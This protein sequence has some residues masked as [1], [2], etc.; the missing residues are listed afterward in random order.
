[1]AHQYKTWRE[2]FN[3][4]VSNLQTTGNLLKTEATIVQEALI[5]TRRDL[6]A[7]MD[8]I[9]PELNSQLLACLDSIAD[10]TEVS[11]DFTLMVKNMTGQDQATMARI[12]A[13][14]ENWTDPQPASVALDQAHENL[15]ILKDHA[16]EFIDPIFEIKRARLIVEEHNTLHKA[17][18]DETTAENFREFRR[19]KYATSADYRSGHNTLKAYVP[20]HGS[21]ENDI[22]R[23]K[24]LTAQYEQAQAACD[25]QQAAIN[26]LHRHIGE[27]NELHGE[28]TALEATLYGPEDILNTVRGTLAHLCEKNWG[29]AKMLL[30]NAG[31]HGRQ[32]ST[33]VDKIQGLE[34]AAEVMIMHRSWM[35]KRAADVQNLRLGFNPLSKPSDELDEV[36]RP[37]YD[38]IGLALE[39]LEQTEAI[40]TSRTGPQPA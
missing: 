36:V 16:G 19:I 27:M 26:D 24:E 29:F 34:I 32:L 15:K 33:I 5:E 38:D 13:L 1:M 6:R 8:G 14:K 17:R 20:V 40:R 2:L 3:A 28:F 4:L 21:F 37:I 11:R 18:L 12:D 9:V 31:D 7:A 25:T 22:A 39:M 23:L 35:D 30:A 10:K